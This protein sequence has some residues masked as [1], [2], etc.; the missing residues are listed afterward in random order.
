MYRKCFDSQRIRSFLWHIY[1]LW[2]HGLAC[3]EFYSSRM[4]EATREFLPERGLGNR[5]VEDQK[6]RIGNI[7]HFHANDALQRK[8]W[9]LKQRWAT[10][11][12]LPLI[13]CQLNQCDTRLV[14]VLFKIKSGMMKKQTGFIVISTQNVKIENNYYKELLIDDLTKI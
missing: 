12:L 3:T 13:C 9:K 1:N 11:K 6:L 5:Y 10:F 2:W 8:K 7:F 4:S 14:L